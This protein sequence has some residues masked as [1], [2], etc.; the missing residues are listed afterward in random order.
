[1]TEIPVF[2]VRY[3]ANRPDNKSLNG[4]FFIKEGSKAEDRTS[5]N[6]EQVTY[7][8]F[9]FNGWFF[10]QN[11]FDFYSTLFDRNYTLNAAYVM[12]KPE[13]LPT[14][15]IS[16]V[17]NG[18]KHE[19]KLNANILHDLGDRKWIH[20]YETASGKYQF[21]HTADEVFFDVVSAKNTHKLTLEI[22]YIDS[23]G[24]TYSTSVEH[25][26][27]VEI[28][29]APLTVVN[30]TAEDRLYDAKL[31]VVLQGGELSGIKTRNGVLDKVQAVSMP[32]KGRL[33]DKNAGTNKAVIFDDI[34][35][36]GE[37]LYN[38]YF[39][40]PTVTVN[41]EKSKVSLNGASAINKIY[42]GNTLVRISA[43]GFVGILGADD[44]SFDSTKTIAYTANKNVGN[45]KLVSVE[46]VGLSGKD[47]GNYTCTSPTE[48][49]VDITK[50]MLDIIDLHTAY[51]NRQYNQTTEVAL[52]GGTL[53][54]IIPGDIVSCIMPTVGNA[55]SQYA[56]KWGVIVTAPELT[57]TDA[58][59]YD[60]QISYSLSINIDRKD[61]EITNLSAKDREYNRTGN[62]E[63]TKGELSGIFEGD[64]VVFN[65]PT[66]GT[67]GEFSAGKKKVDI[68][69]GELGGEHAYN[70]R[71]VLPEQLTVTIYPKTLSIEGIFAEER[72]YDGTNRVLL[73]D[74]NAKLNGVE[75]GDTVSFQLPEF[76][77]LDSASVGNGKK[78][79]IKDIV[80]K[81]DTQPSILDSYTIQT[82]VITTN[83]LRR[84]I[85]ASWDNNI[86]FTY[87]GKA[88]SPSAVALTGV[89]GEFAVL[90]ISGAQVN[91][92]NNYTA[93]A[94]L[95]SVT[96][97]EASNYILTNDTL[98]FSIVPRN[99]TVEV[100]Q[101]VTYQEN[102]VWTNSEWNGNVKGLVHTHTFSGTIKTVDSIVKLYESKNGGFEY[103]NIA[104][105]DGDSN[106]VTNN[107][108]I[109]YNLTVNITASAITYTVE[110]YE[111]YFDNNEHT[112]ALNVSTL[113]ADV[114]YSKN[115]TDFSNELPTFTD[116]GEYTVHFRVKATNYTTVTSS[117]SVSILPAELKVTITANGGIYNGSSI[118]ANYIVEGAHGPVDVT[119]TYT[120]MS[121]GG[122]SYDDT[123]APS[124]AGEYTVTATIDENNYI[125]ERTFVK[126]SISRA[127][128]LIN[129]DGVQTNY[130]YNGNKQVVNSGAILNHDETT[131]EYKN[132][133]FTEVGNGSYT[134]T[135][136][137]EESYNYSAVETTVQI[138]VKQ[139][140]LRDETKDYTGTYDGDSHGITVN[141]SG[142]LG[143][144]D[145]SRVIIEY[146][147]DGNTWTS[148]P[149]LVK[150]VDDSK[151]IHYRMTSEDYEPLS[152]TAEIS[153]SRKPLEIK[154][155]TG[156]EQTYNNATKVLRI[157]GG[158]LE[159]AISGDLVS[160]VV[161]IEGTMAD[162]HVGQNKLV[163][164]ADITLTG[165]H[166]GNYTLI[167]PDVFVTVTQRSLSVQGF[168]VQNKTYDG[169]TTITVSATGATLITPLP[170]DDVS[171][172]EI[173]A[174]ANDANV[175]QK[176]INITSITLAGAD[177][178]NYT[179]T[180]P[181]GWTANI[182]S[183]PLSFT[184][185]ADGG[186][187]NGNPIGASINVSGYLPGESGTIIL[188]YN[189][190]T[191]GGIAYNDTNAPVL[192]G[193][194]TVT[195]SLVDNQNY[196]LGEN[197][198]KQFVITR[199]NSVIDIGNMT[200]EYTYT[201]EPQIINSGATLNHEDASLLYSDNVFTD[202]GTGIYTVVISVV[203]TDNYESA[204]IEVEIK[205]KKNS[206][207]MSNVKFADGSFIADGKVYSL[208]VT[209]LPN[210][211]TVQYVNN[212]H[213]EAG[214]YIVT[215][216]F[217]GDYDN[218]EKI[219][220]MTA[221]LNL[222]R[223]NLTGNGMELSSED[224]FDADIELDLQSVNLSDYSGLKLDDK[225]IDVLA[226]RN[227]SLIK[228][229]LPIGV[230]GTITIKMVIDESMRHRDDL[231]VVFIADNGE[232]INMNATRE[233]DYMVFNTDHNSVYAIVSYT[234]MPQG[235]TTGAI[236][237]IVIGI[238]LV[239]I[240]LI[241]IIVLLRRRR[242]YPKNDNDNNTYSSQTLV[243]I[244]TN[245]NSADESMETDKQTEF[246]DEM[247]AE[248]KLDA[249]G[250]VDV[251][252]VENQI[253]DDRLENELSASMCESDETESTENQ[254]ADSDESNGD[255]AKEAEEE[256]AI[257]SDETAISNDNQTDN[258]EN[259]VIEEDA[260]VNALESPV[261]ENP[262]NNEVS[263]ADAE[264]IEPS[265]ETAVVF[266]SA[267]QSLEE[268]FQ[269]LSREQKDFYE[270][271]RSYALE[272]T[273]A[274]SNKTQS[275][276]AVKVGRKNI[277]KF[278]IKRNT[279]VAAFSLEHPLLKLYKKQSVEDEGGAIKSKPTEVFV[280]NVA[281][282]KAAKDM[283]DIVVRQIELEKEE[284]R[285]LRNSKKKAKSTEESKG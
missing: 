122:V 139:A 45:G 141:A 78:V 74:K 94:T 204:S 116:A 98:M 178:D 79:E 56:G 266:V 53:S 70:Y 163:T 239:L 84:Q 276:E 33:A 238:I 259:R 177:K 93:T 250:D 65:M 201:G 127:E 244:N 171:V 196:V 278:S 281:A 206:Y 271:L 236:V 210:G 189:G 156:G 172:V 57:G 228:N 282:F 169:N 214:I 192:A 39:I 229:G 95:A 215:A 17:Y 280:S 49:R 42:D 255:E 170:G 150:Y 217:N 81:S 29:Q 175:G 21:E 108:D 6:A 4:G 82:H 148:T 68:S 258:D 64:T 195:A 143:N 47:A 248:D 62:V 23:W 212:G 160:P 254:D 134:V 59:N 190:T 129:I 119:L 151:T 240:V 194:Y 159:G 257:S 38:Y 36:E 77:I 152:G 138:S 76:G 28:R 219:D 87:N 193:S 135:I 103:V 261:E 126:F 27:S 263:I 100:N 232:I 230:N 43:S 155:V 63:L 120:G 50:K 222:K 273:G 3:I 11:K 32:V 2:Y 80:L 226:A 72:V 182:A 106:N 213:S 113:G 14:P 205:V 52:T 85:T 202:V 104:I 91:A 272:K 183:K 71:I 41:I 200:T 132:N 285:K 51:S 137:A 187:Y 247:G 252:C 260:E 221:T 267:G 207:D 265:Q 184:L 164:M 256:L 251:N 96:N 73:S 166:A 149:I 66:S 176:D 35:V 270:R 44:I 12:D 203:Q 191:N 61:V 128:A 24:T 40:Q 186:A 249:S 37:D 123:I 133:E 142:F 188:N 277:V 283:I 88:Q 121:N 1:M 101:S 153:I 211:V 9:T 5:I 220:N 83:I 102:Q 112:I 114:E 199:A 237:G 136:L 8:G 124:N 107:Y 92:N 233:G 208:F 140:T 131:L 157:S 48:L 30:L 16:V 111:G 279:T 34:V 125:L 89:N 75:T 185:T 147:I 161:P 60:V 269:S 54:G 223:A 234:A 99:V 231:M 55:E 209:G 25:T 118:E 26:F 243:I 46:S 10:G 179:V 225:L 224:G 146:S 58:K 154:D 90:E 235:L 7:A 109:S 168:S 67:I 145:M 110:N 20:T 227:V 144:D 158:R 31:D 117:A 13:I 167:Q 105:I 97:G 216:V 284:A 264:K 262:L 268:A 86:S 181:T 18:E 19:I 180:M 115:G 275:Y 242:K 253:E 198:S 22:L 274:V 15:D 241:L 165:E 246:S 69:W 130:T 173:I 218:Y 162:K 245:E 174:S 197:V